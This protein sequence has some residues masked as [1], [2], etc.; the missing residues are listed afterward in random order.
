MYSLYS[1]V[2]EG[3][4]DHV[5][6]TFFN[7]YATNNT[8]KKLTSG[9]AA[10][11]ST[12]ETL[13]EIESKIMYDNLYGK[14]EEKLLPAIKVVDCES[15]E[16]T[17]EEIN[18][19]FIFKIIGKSYIHDYTRLTE[20]MGKFNQLGEIIATSIYGSLGE[21]VK[22]TT[23]IKN[24]ANTQGLSQ[25]KKLLE[26]LK[27]VS[28]FFNNNSFDVMIL[29]EIKDS[30]IAFKG[31][32]KREFLRVDE[33]RLRHLYSNQPSMPWVMVGQ[34]TF[35]QMEEESSNQEVSIDEA[36]DERSISDSYINMINASTNVESVFSSSKNFK[37]IHIAPIAIYVE[38]DVNI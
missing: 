2:F 13:T 21:P 38:Q 34:L 20:F 12:E 22:K 27:F 9:Q 37:K 24:I 28:E 8:G 15:Q 5:T 23:S 10:N 36:N 14:L 29:P 18:N 30:N 35:V 31:V 32:L 16:L 1:Q 19:T 7:R 3:V 4:A 25:D 6:R 33:N 11:S 26:N 17:M